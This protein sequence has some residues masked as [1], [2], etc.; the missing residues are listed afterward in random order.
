[1]YP[2]KVTSDH[3]LQFLPLYP[4]NNNSHNELELFDF[5]GII[6]V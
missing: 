5:G 2:S 3:V 6:D 1:M 4:R